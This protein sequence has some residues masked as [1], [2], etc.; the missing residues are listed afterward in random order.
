M[1]YLDLG[2]RE[3]LVEMQQNV[4]KVTVPVLQS[5]LVCH[6]AAIVGESV[7]IPEVDVQDE[8]IW[9]TAPSFQKALPS[10]CDSNS[11]WRAAVLSRIE[12]LP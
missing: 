5:F 10:V 9:W 3:H 6:P 4:P 11:C 2:F 8:N 1:I 7:H 12:I